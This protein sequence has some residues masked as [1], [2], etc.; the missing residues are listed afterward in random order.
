VIGKMIAY[1]VFN[2]YFSNPNIYDCLH[3]FRAYREF[4]GI[5]LEFEERGSGKNKTDESRVKF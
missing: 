2:Q 4:M 3:C 5:L 1:D